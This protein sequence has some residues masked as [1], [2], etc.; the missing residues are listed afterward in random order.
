MNFKYRALTLG[1]FAAMA[2]AGTAQ[3]V[4]V[5]GDLLEVY[6]NLYPQYQTVTFG[7]SS[8]T[9]S[10]V[11]TMTKGKTGTQTNT[12]AAGAVSVN[13]IIPVNSYIGFK[14]KKSVGELTLGYDLQGVINI[15]STATNP[16][17]MSEPRDAFVYV[18]H[19]TLG[20]LQAGQQDTIYKRYGDRVRMLNVSSS[21][22]VST[23]NII[24]NTTWGNK[25]VSTSFNTRINGQ[26]AWNS[27]RMNGFEVGY[28]LRQDPTKTATKNAGLNSIGINWTNSIYYIGL[29]QEVHNDYFAFSGTASTAAAGSI[30]NAAAGLRSKDTGNRVSFGYRDKG[31]RIGADA[32][33]LNYTETSTQANG[34]RSHKF[35]TWQVTGEYDLNSQVTLAAQYASNGAGN[36]T[37]NGAISCSTV[38]L[39]GDLVGFG[40]K[41][42]LDRN[43]SLFALAA[44]GTANSGAVLSLGS[45][46]GKTAIGGTIMPFAVGINARF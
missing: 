22:F 4:Q 3:A 38:G 15:D 28:S 29:A 1:C 32:A 14:G 39:G 18:S 8:A 34:F 10:S 42:V 16:A 36:C 33:S 43:F 6:G 44:K 12:F 13:K 19:K 45:N 21:N 24:S 20:T 46:A 41:Y 9:G 23:S 40:M 37:L 2:L 11:S 27:P 30:Y 35:N 17:F 26:L 7:D 31:V 25:G 5:A